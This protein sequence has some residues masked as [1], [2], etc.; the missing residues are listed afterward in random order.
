MIDSSIG[1][2]LFFVSISCFFNS[3]I[4]SKHCFHLAYAL[5]MASLS[6]WLYL[7]RDIQSSSL[8]Y[9][10]IDG[11]ISHKLFFGLGRSTLILVT[12]GDYL[13]IIGV[14]QCPFSSLLFFLKVLLCLH[15]GAFSDC[16]HFQD[17][18]DQDGWMRSFLIQRQAHRGL[19]QWIHFSISYAFYLPGDASISR[20]SPYVSEPRISK[21]EA[22]SFHRSLFGETY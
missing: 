3:Y 1:V 7:L 10:H 19:L 22:A 11:K 16:H 9:W 4:Q 17:K 20:I 8:S 5:T 6:L 12:M 21:W 13:L 18:P 15:F 2:M 14:L